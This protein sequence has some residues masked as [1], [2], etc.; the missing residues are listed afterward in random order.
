[1]E[2]LRL[3]SKLDDDFLK[4][5]H[6]VS[7]HASTLNKLEK[8][9]VNLWTKKLCQAT[10]NCVWKRNRN[11]YSKLLRDMLGEGKL[12]AP[13]DRLPPQGDLPQL[14]TSSVKTARPATSSKPY[15]PRGGLGSPKSKAG[16]KSESN[17][18]T[19]RAPSALSSP[20]TAS[21]SE[22]MRLKIEGRILADELNEARLLSKT[23][24]AQLARRDE[25]IRLQQEHIEQLRQE[26][27][28]RG[29]A[30]Q[31][32]TI[33]KLAFEPSEDSDFLSYLDSFHRETAELKLENQALFS[34]N[35]SF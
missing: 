23:A 24:Q 3:S 31:E 11:A 7:S 21:T 10:L 17:F 9:R 26:L 4:T 27:F 35:S 8:V 28:S 1:M 25:I 19:T 30:K 14:L 2:D 33:R 16:T 22:I 18:R 32:S 20:K 5:M 15:S 13:F 6:E 29:N 34:A 12:K